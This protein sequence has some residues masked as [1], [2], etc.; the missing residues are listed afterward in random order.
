MAGGCERLNLMSET[1]LCFILDHTV[2]LN[3]MPLRHREVGHHDDV[4]IAGQYQY[5]SDSL[6]HGV[7][8]E[9]VDFVLGGLSL[10]S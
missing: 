8:V 1:C 9:E 7:D 10:L 4:F 5:P 3:I 6:R 2:D